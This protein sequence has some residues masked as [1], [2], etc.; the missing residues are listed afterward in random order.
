VF[1]KLA[2]MRFLDA[3]GGV[4]GTVDGVLGVG[5][6]GQGGGLVGGLI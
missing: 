6:D 2:K 1:A 5:G 3:L 4:G